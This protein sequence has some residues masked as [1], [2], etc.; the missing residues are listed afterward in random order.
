MIVPAL[1][2]YLKLLLLTAANHTNLTVVLAF[3]LLIVPLSAPFVSPAWSQLRDALT[4]VVELMAQS[5]QS[6]SFFP[7]KSSWAQQFRRHIE[8]YFIETGCHLLQAT[9][10]YRFAP[11]L[12]S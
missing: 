10:L 5:L 2:S 3:V 12:V 11:P 9:R 6:L 1:L 4:F 8:T 7:Q